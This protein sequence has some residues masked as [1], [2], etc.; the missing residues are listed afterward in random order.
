MRASGAVAA[1]VHCECETLLV[2]LSFTMASSAVAGA[3]A[4]AAGV[5]ALCSVS[6]LINLA[7]SVSLAC[8]WSVVLAFSAL[9]TKLHQQNL[10]L[11]CSG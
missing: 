5:K 1:S 9:P 7:G 3:V 11:L 10:H 6:A 4:A 8:I 2:L